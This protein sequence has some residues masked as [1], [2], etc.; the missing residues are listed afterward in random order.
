MA[1]KQFVLCLT[2]LLAQRVSRPDTSGQV[3]RTVVCIDEGKIVG[4]TTQ[5][6][7]KTLIRIKQEKKQNPIYGTPIR[8]S[9]TIGGDNIFGVPVFS[10]DDADEFRAALEKAFATNGPVIVEARISSQEYDD[11]VLKKDKPG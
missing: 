11:L 1:L 8:P 2:K 3:L 5:I 4:H 6:T 7:D 9:G 10:A